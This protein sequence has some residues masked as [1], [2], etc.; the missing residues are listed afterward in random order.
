MKINF[1]WKGDEFDDWCKLCILSH[2]KVGHE[3][4]IWVSGNWPQTNAWY[5]ITNQVVVGDADHIFNVDEF[6]SKGGNFQTASALWRFHFLYKY[7]GWYC[8]TDAYAIQHFPEK[9]WA[10][11]SAETEDLLSI[12]VLKIPKNHPI[13]MNC[14][15][16]IQYNWGNVKVFTK[17]YKE[18]FGHTKGTVPYKMFYPWT[19]KNWSYVYS[20]MSIGDLINDGVYSV[21]LYHTM[22]KR[23]GAKYCK[24]PDT[25][26]MELIEFAEEKIVL[27]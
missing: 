26:L 27:R 9:E 19:W 18:H 11:C 3:V 10:V 24:K 21:H 15:N 4:I 5:E 6:I 1:F 22:L 23:V 12:G 20:N 17:A 8:D 14:I 25:L 13:M 7:G 2:I 16:D